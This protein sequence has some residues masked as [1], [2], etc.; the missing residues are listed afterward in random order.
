MAASPRFE[1]VGEEADPKNPA[2]SSAGA[3][4]AAMLQL[5]ISALGQRAL[6]AIASLFSIA[7]A[8]SVFALYWKVLPDPSTYSLVGIGLYS[9][10]II[11]LHVVKARK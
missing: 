7:L 1:V 3:I 2:E 10:F 11:A 8:G 9:I 4:S 6:I 5:A